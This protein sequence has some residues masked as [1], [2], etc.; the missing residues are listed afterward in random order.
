MAKRAKSKD[1]PRLDINSPQYEPRMDPD[2]VDYDPDYDPDGMGT[3]GNEETRRTPSNNDPASQPGS[4]GKSATLSGGAKKMPTPEE[5]E[6]A[7]ARAEDIQRDVDDKLDAGS[8]RGA[9]R[10]EAQAIADGV[11]LL[12]KEAVVVQDDR[13]NPVTAVRGIPAT[14]LPSFASATNPNLMQNEVLSDGTPNP[15]FEQAMAHPYAGG[16]I[17]TPPTPVPP[18]EKPPPEPPLGE[19]RE[20]SRRA[21]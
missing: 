14:A 2:N 5:D 13:G 18:E 7:K 8:Y 15:E 9:A 12:G 19:S 20:G 4:L 11:S 1:D 21:A 10:V 6:E 16:L 3:D 17:A